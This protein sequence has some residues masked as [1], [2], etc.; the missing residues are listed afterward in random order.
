LRFEWDD[1][2]NRSNQAKH[3]LSFETAL[4]VFED[5]NQVSVQDRHEGSEERWQTLG[6]VDGLVVIRVAHTWRE[7]ADEEV[8][9]IIS[10][11]KATQ[12]ERMRCEQ[13]D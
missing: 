2:K 5:P 8:I 4:F 12:R 6:L 11:R 1:L 7:D 3:G 13:S 10:A 9:R